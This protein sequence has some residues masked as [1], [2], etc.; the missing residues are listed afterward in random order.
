M[1][2]LLPSHPAWIFFWAFIILG[3]LVLKLDLKYAIDWKDVLVEANGLIF[4]IFFLGILFYL[5]DEWRQKKDRI[6]RHFELI[7]SYRLQ[8]EESSSHRIQYAVRQLNNEK[9]T[10]IDLFR[11][12][13]PNADFNEVK[14]IRSQLQDVN[15]EGAVL[16]RADFSESDLSFAKMN[17]A[18]LKGAVLFKANLNRAELRE[19]WLNHANLR[20]ADLSCAEALLHES[21]RKTGVPF[22]V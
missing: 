19:S 16:E 17:S 7:N 18:N 14:L 10:Q 21:P 1:A 15:F 6:Q 13:L 4:D 11:C 5:Y 2:K 8:K 9:H 3:S 12:T 22:P 20:K